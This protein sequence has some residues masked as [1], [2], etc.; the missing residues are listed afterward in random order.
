[1][2]MDPSLP[3]LLL[4]AQRAVAEVRQAAT[5]AARAAS[6]ANVPGWQGVAAARHLADLGA[7]QVVVARAVG[8]ISALESGLGAAATTAGQTVQAEAEAARAA[9]AAAAAQPGQAGQVYGPPWPG[10]TSGYPTY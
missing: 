10:A 5:N 7:L 4:Q 1:M 8:Q 6:S 9:A 3:G 2:T